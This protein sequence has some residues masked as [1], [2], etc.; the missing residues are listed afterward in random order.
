ME[1]INNYCLYRHIKPNGETFYIG[2]S[3][4][5]KRPYEKLT[6]NALW[7]KIV[8]KYG[9]EVQIIKQNSSKEEIYELEKILVS[10]YGRID[11]K[12]G[13]LANMTDGG[14]GV[15]NKS[16]ETKQKISNAQLGNKNHRWG[17]RGE[18]NPQFGKSRT[19]EVI[20]KMKA[21]HPDFSGKNNPNYG[22]KHSDETKMKISLAQQG[23]SVSGKLVLNKETGIFYKSCKEASIQHSINYSTLKS[24]LNGTNENKTNLIYV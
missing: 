8:N 10:W 23:V 5:L 9:Y 1:K 7:K 17:I 18:L 3:S 13:T 19:K 14:E 22:K 11:L 6:R 12:T 20:E 24:Y 21:N 4:N 16:I 15:L 2:I